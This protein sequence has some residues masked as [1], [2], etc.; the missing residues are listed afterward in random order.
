MK[1]IISVT[2]C[3]DETISKVI[4]YIEIKFYETIGSF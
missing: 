4:D 3:A 2:Q 1:T